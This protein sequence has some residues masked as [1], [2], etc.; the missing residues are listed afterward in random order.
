MCRLV[1]RL[2]ALVA[3]GLQA[4]TPYG[5][6]EEAGP[7]PA[8]RRIGN[9]FPPPPLFLHEPGRLQGTQVDSSRLGGCRQTLDVERVRPQTTRRQLVT[10][11]R[12][13]GFDSR[14]RHPPCV[15]GVRSLAVRASGQESAGGGRSVSSR[16]RQ[17]RLTSVCRNRERE[18]DEILGIISTRP[19][20]LSA[21]WRGTSD[22]MSESESGESTRRRRDDQGGAPAQVVGGRAPRPRLP[23]TR[24]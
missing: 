9:R 4:T 24:W 17:Q 18:L 1:R 20:R 14:R 2:R 19:R 21:A 13:H 22:E 3:A 23:R 15:Q 16:D 6:V 11:T 7:A 8:A 10:E 5:P 12:S